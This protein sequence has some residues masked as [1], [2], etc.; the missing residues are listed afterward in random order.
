MNH[1]WCSAGAVVVIVGLVW[2]G[3]DRSGENQGQSASVKPRPVLN[4]LLITLDTTRADR[5]GSY[6]YDAARTPTLDALAAS[7]VRFERAHCQV[8][9][10]LPSHVSLLTGMYPPVHGVRINGAMA[11]GS[12]LATLAERFKQRGYQTAAFVSAFVLHSRFGLGRGFDHYDDD[13]GSAGDDGSASVERRGDD[14]CDTSLDWLRA[15]KREPFFAWVHFFDPHYPYE[16]PE[17]FRDQLP[18]AYDGEI[19]FV[20]TQVR[21]LVDW[22]EAEGLR[23]RT[24]IVVAG[25]H[26]EAFN[27][28][29][30][31]QHGL[32]LYDVTLRV[33]LILAGSAAVPEGKVV[34]ADVELVDVFPT[35]LD[36]MGWESPPVDGRSLSDTWGGGELPAR[37][38][39]AETL[40]P[41]ASYG[42]AS[43]RSLTKGRWKYIEAPRPELYDRDA[44]PGE[45]RNVLSQRSQLASQLRDEL[46]DVEDAMVSHAT[47]ITARDLQSVG[48]L[49]SLGYVAGSAD[50][51]VEDTDAPLRDPK[52]M[53]QVYRRHMRGN[54]LLKQGRFA[55]AAQLLEAAAGE[56]PESDELYTSLGRAYL[57]LGRSEDAEKAFEA[58]LRKVPDEPHKLWALG[59]ALR[60]QNKLNEAIGC[61]RRALG[62][63]PDFG[64]AHRGLGMC[65]AAQ[66]DFEKA[67]EHCRRHMELSPGSPNALVNLANVCL[68]LKRYG[69]AVPLLQEALAAAPDNSFAH[70]SLWQALRAVGRTEEAVVALRAAHGALPGD[71]GLTCSLAWLLATS[72]SSSRCNPEEALPLAQ[73]CCEAYP[74]SA[75][76]LDVLAACYAAAGDFSGAVTTAE[77][78][79]SLAE[80][81][82]DASFVKKIQARLKLYRSKRPYKE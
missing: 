17:P 77:R 78:A 76:S 12:D 6:G 80:S 74:E 33:P 38:V 64:E 75:A 41:H 56:S 34:T 81:Q 29:D 3:C 40:Y 60:R 55:E 15:K 65:Y 70:R 44:D 47:T 46:I 79:L 72:E 36:L 57:E 68:A 25:D 20:D 69:E 71:A 42:W 43:L 73:A 14:V 27:E 10:T 67:Y 66:R 31:A 18:N 5:L 48:Q 63:L 8:P 16:P 1:R 53:V 54:L 22:L 4:V 24:I 26:G 59:E 7:G 23:D 28:H 62:V 50:N 45:L 37:R 61:F 58:S 13:L 11:L 52:D 51:I 39:Y 30:E 9:L 32:F 35:I 82:S 49:Q 19:A 2:A 21:R